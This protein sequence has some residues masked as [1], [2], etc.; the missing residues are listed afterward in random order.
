MNDKRLNSYRRHMSCVICNAIG[1][2]KKGRAPGWKGQGWLPEGSGAKAI[3]AGRPMEWL[4]ADPGKEKGAGLRPS[5]LLRD[6]SR[7]AC[8]LAGFHV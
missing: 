5:P 7:D 8:C 1:F 4:S 2:Q 3:L 6:R